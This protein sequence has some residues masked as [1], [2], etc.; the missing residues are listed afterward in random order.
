MSQEKQ[1]RKTVELILDECYN[2]I[3]FLIKNSDKL[4]RLSNGIINTSNIESFRVGVY[5]I[6]MANMNK[7]IL[8]NVKIDLILK[9]LDEGVVDEM[10]CDKW[11]YFLN[12]EK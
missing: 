12:T 1:L 9:L 4:F 3:K 10:T 8:E 7:G 6:Y 2:Q 11:V 5:L